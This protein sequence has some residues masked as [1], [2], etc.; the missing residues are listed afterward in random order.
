MLMRRWVMPVRGVN[1]RGGLSALLRFF[2][3]IED[4][5]TTLLDRALRAT[6]MLLDLYGWEYV[7]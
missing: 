1:V 5:E 2:D 4:M 6:F 3:A 7:L